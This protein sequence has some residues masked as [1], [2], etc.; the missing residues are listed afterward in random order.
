MTEVVDSRSRKEI[1]LMCMAEVK[2]FWHI[3]IINLMLGAPEQLYHCVDRCKD[4]SG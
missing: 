3:L 2:L 1:L 4:T